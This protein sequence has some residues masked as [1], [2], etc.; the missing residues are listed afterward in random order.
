MK[1]SIKSKQ[2]G[3]SLFRYCLG[4]N[5]TEGEIQ[6]IKMSTAQE[7]KVA[8]NNIIEQK[9]N[10]KLR[11][12]GLYDEFKERIFMLKINMINLFYKRINPRI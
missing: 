1:N 9:I 3:N 8:I 10:D 12:K 4:K 6:I 7:R 11:Q 5:L 2:L